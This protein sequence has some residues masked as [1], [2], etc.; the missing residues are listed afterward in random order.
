MTID[1]LL[2]LAYNQKASDLHCVVGQPPVLRVDNVLQAVTNATICTPQDLVAYAKKLCTPQQ[3]EK[4]Y[5]LKDID[6][7]YELTLGRFR[8]NLHW[9]R[10]NIGIV[11]RVI[12]PV[13]PTLQDVL[14]PPVVE[15]LCQQRSGL[16]LVTGPAGSGKSTSL[17]AMLNH[18]NDTRK[19]HIITL[20]DPIEFIH[21]SK[22]SLV[23]QR[24]LDSDMVSFASALKHVLRQDPD[25][26]MVGEMRDIETIATTVT[27]AE[28][29]HLVLA[30]LHTHNAA[31]SIDRIIDIFPAYQQEQ[32]RLQL[33]LTLVGIISQ[34][35]I[36]QVN[37][38][39]IAAR[40]VL[41]Q[42]PAVSN[43]IREN[44]IGQLQSLIQMSAQDGMVTMDQDLRRLIMGGFITKEA[45]E[46]TMGHKIDIS[47]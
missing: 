41:V 43:I 12:R 40:E 47:S 45:A 21:D 10:G 11:A 13:I 24:Q 42:T 8:V 15:R 2:S 27:L 18:I 37:G 23:R 22:Q 3:L 46:M 6:C 33:S 28:T 31:Q 26:I 32:I 38:G 20:E 1:E 14:M 7:S 19:A 25:V 5:T 36:P 29:G 34:R 44:K 17:A 39:R 16:M 35:L 9:E 4:L 30:T